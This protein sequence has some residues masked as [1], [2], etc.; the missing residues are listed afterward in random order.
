MQSNQSLEFAI[1]ITSA[2]LHSSS[3]TAFEFI[4]AALHK[5]HQVKRIFFYQEGVYHGSRL[6]YLENPLLME[7]WQNLAKDHEIA[8]ILCSASSAKRGIMGPAEAIY[9]EKNTHNLAEGFQIASLSLWF[10]SML[11]AQRTMIFG[12]SL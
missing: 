12:E 6:I 9:F 1:L 11:S 10:E 2:P 3:T 8:L 4:K 5:K 7:R